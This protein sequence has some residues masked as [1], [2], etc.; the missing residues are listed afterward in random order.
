MTIRDVSSIVLRDT[1]IDAPTLPG[2]DNHNDRPEIEQA[3]TTGQGISLRYSTSLGLDAVY[4]AVAL[5]DGSILRMAVP[6]A[7]V[8]PFSMR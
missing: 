5:A 6:S 1:H 3:L 4:A 2:L 8:R 7:D